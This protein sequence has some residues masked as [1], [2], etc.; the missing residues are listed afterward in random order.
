MKW[1]E[2]LGGPLVLVPKSLVG[3]WG[4]S[5]LEHPM[6]GDDYGRACSIEDYQGVIPIGSGFGLV[7]WGGCDPTTI[8]ETHRGWV[9]LRWQG[10][11]SDAMMLECVYKNIDRAQVLEQMEHNVIE[12]EYVLFDSVYSGKDLEESLDLKLVPGAYRITTR[13]YSEPRT[14]FLAHLFER[15]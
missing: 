5:N 2:S 3:A 10:A 4:G 6:E 12:A 7:L 1:I 11:D 9:L 15:A 13:S 14:E 8:L